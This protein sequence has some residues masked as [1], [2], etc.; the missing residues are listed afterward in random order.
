MQETLST[1]WQNGL[2][3]P[4]IATSF[5]PLQ[6]GYLWKELL[7]T[8]VS[9][10]ES[11]YACSPYLMTPYHNPINIAQRRFNRAEKSTRSSIERAFGILKSRFYIPHSE[12]RM[13]P[14]RVCTS[15]PHAVCSNIAINFN[16]PGV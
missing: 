12:I 11:G 15:L 1:L 10:L 7:W 14:E 3:K 13:S 16:E 6:L 8:M 4:M 5:K 9:F 2:G